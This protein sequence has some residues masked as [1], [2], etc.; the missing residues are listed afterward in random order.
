MQLVTRS[1]SSVLFSYLRRAWSTGEDLELCCQ[2]LAD[3]SSVLARL[4]TASLYDKMV[5]RQETAGSAADNWFNVVH[6]CLGLLAVCS[7]TLHNS[8]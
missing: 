8:L 5:P 7:N 2:I 1:A 4:P 3:A 6:R